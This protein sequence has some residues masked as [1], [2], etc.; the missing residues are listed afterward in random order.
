MYKKNG[1]ESY[2]GKRINGNYYIPLLTSYKVTKPNGITI[3]NYKIS[4]TYNKTNMVHPKSMHPI[5]KKN[6]KYFVSKPNETFKKLQ[7]PNKTIDFGKSLELPN[8][9]KNANEYVKWFG[10]GSVVKYGKTFWYS[11][12]AKTRSHQAN[13]NFLKRLI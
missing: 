10:H 13:G 8:G 1:I 11:N 3:K 2:Y 6:G 7:K 12:A 4:K 5:V 9:T